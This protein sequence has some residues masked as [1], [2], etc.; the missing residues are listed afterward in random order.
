MNAKVLFCR[1]C[2]SQLYS[3]DEIQLTICN[4][5]KKAKQQTTGNDDF[6]CWACG[7]KLTDISQIAQGVCHNCKASIQRSLKIKTTKQ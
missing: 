5:C 6:F 2:G 3:I 1:I 7:K 4:N